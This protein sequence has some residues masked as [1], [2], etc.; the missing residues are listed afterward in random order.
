[1]FIHPHMFVHPHRPP[2]LFCAPAWFWSICILWGVVICLNVFGDSSLTSPLF[3]GA[4]PLITPPT[5]LLVPCTLLF[6]GILVSYV[7]LSPSNEGFGGVPPSVG[8]VGGTSALQL[9]MCSFLYF[10]CSA[11]CLMF[12]PWLQLLLLQLQWY[13]LACHQCHQ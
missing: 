1:M 10:F 8:E 4:S 13:L 6:A 12:R 11:L 3:E 7:G 5:S 2:M 9:S